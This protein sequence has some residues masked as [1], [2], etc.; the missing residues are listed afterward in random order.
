MLRYIGMIGLHITSVRTA[1]VCH[2]NF[3]VTFGQ[4]FL[5]LMLTFN[6]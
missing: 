1:S 4:S 6:L 2:P 3:N 5:E